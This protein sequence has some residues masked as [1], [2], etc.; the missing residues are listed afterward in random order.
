[1]NQVIEVTVGDL[2]F[3]FVLAAMLLVILTLLCV[4]AVRDYY[5][6]KRYHRRARRIRDRKGRYDNDNWTTL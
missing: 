3:L 6:W 4:A 2:V 1:M 5:Q